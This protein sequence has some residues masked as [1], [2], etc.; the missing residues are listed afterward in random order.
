MLGPKIVSFL[1]LLRLVLVVSCG[2]VCFWFF[3]RAFFGRS[4]AHCHE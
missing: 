2:L 1:F 4:L 3:L